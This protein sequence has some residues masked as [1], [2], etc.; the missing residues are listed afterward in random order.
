MPLFDDNVTKP[1]ANKLW[2]NRTGGFYD[3]G[4]IENKISDNI[5]QKGLKILGEGQKAVS[6]FSMMALRYTDIKAADIS[7]ITYYKNYLRKKGLPFDDNNEF[8]NPNKDAMA[9]A[10]TM[11]ERSQGANT[12]VSQADMWEYSKGLSSIFMPFM[13]FAVQANVRMFNNYHNIYNGKNRGEALKD[14]AAFNAEIALFNVVKLGISA[15]IVNGLIPLLKSAIIGG[16]D[17]D[18]VEKARK[19]K[20][21]REGFWQQL[22]QDHYGIMPLFD[23]NVTKPIANKL[24]KNRTGSDV[25]LIPLYNGDKSMKD[26]M[27]LGLFQGAIN[28]YYDISKDLDIMYNN[29][30]FGGFDGMEKEVTEYEYKGNTYKIVHSGGYVSKDMYISN[31]QEGRFKN[32]EVPLDVLVDFVNNPSEFKKVKTLA[33]ESASVDKKFKLELDD[34]QKAFAA[35][36]FAVDALS[37]MGASDNLLNR[38]NN[39]MRKELTKKTIKKNVYE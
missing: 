33:W 9:Y 29:P 26:G 34:N 18:E 27:Q 22:A 11:V 16:D 6:D 14:I 21:L 3:T 38:T 12:D 5:A 30:V 17:D 10:E 15:S 24:W 25:P 13:A 23:D 8:K 32:I 20:Q 28:K 7:W 36:I 1:I 2:K 4:K 39:A 31:R 35:F 37:L 19:A